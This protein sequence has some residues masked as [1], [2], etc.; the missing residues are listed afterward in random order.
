MAAAAKINEM[1]KRDKCA[2]AGRPAL[3]AP[4]SPSFAHR[5]PQIPLKCAPSCAPTDQRN[6]FLR[7]N[8]RPTGSA[9]SASMQT[10]KINMTNKRANGRPSVMQA[11]AGAVARENNFKFC[12]RR[13]SSADGQQPAAGGGHARRLATCLPNANCRPIKRPARPLGPS[14]ESAC[15]P[16]PI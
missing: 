3:C 8:S 10:N 15:A 11:G 1:Q 5:P 6:C 14:V 9:R 4:D 2:P 7:R 12:P 13:S 16:S